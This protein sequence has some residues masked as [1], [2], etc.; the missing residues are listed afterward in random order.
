MGIVVNRQYSRVGS[1]CVGHL[2]RLSRVARREVGN[3]RY[4]GGVGVSG[5]DWNAR[6]GN[7]KILGRETRVGGRRKQV[8]RAAFR[9]IHNAHGLS[10]PARQE[11]RK[12]LECR[13]IAVRN[14]VGIHG[15]GNFLSRGPPRLCGG[16]ID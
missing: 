11:S 6:M 13:A 7:T 15:H 9:V 16:M 8:Q 2:K 1:L 3:G 14:N 12:T 5:A 4:T 10:L